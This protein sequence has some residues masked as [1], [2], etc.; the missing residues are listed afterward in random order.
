[1]TRAQLTDEECEFI[2]PHLP[3]REYG[4]H[5]KTLRQQFEGV[6]G[7][8]RTGGQWREIPSEFGVS[9]ASASGVTSACSMPCWRT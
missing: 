4:P 5:P 9:T 7:R 8:F 6:T 3:I 1:M 2:E